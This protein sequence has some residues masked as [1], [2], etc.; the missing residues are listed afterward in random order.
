MYFPRYLQGCSVIALF[1]LGCEPRYFQ[2]KSKTPS[3]VSPYSP[4]QKVSNL[5]RIGM[6]FLVRSICPYEKLYSSCCRDSLC[7]IAQ[8]ITE[9][10]KMGKRRNIEWRR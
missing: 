7:C 3:L 10:V 4:G 5:Y 9:K 6:Y 2:K 8:A 1:Q